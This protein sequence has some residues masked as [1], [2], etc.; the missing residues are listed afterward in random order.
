[1][2][3]ILQWLPWSGAGHI[4]EAYTYKEAYVKLSIVDLVFKR[5]PGIAGHPTS[6]GGIATFTFIFALSNYCFLKDYKVMSFSAML[7]AI[8]N[9]LASQARMG[10][11]TIGFSIIV[12]YIIWVYCDLS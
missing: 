7:F 10:Y 12:F 6:N 3:G 1:M 11:L 5:I 9:T 8:W 4:A 2:I